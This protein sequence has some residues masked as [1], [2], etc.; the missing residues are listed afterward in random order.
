MRTIVPFTSTRSGS[1]R[2]STQCGEQYSLDEIFE[3]LKREVCHDRCD[4]DHA[5][6]RKQ[7]AKRTQHPRCGEEAV[8]EHDHV[9]A[10]DGLGHDGAPIDPALRDLTE[11]PERF[12]RL[13]R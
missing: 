3:K 13:A 8:N 7:A 1:T 5:K 9:V 6:R 4:V 10:G 12:L 2:P 11:L